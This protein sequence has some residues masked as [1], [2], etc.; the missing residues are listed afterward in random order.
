MPSSILQ[1]AAQ[2]GVHLFLKDGALGFKARPGALT[3]ELRAAISANKA[4]L[5]ELLSSRVERGTA[6]R[7]E[8][9][10]PGLRELPLSYAQ[11][12]L[13]LLDQIDGA[14][15][16]YNMPAA[17]RLKGPL[18]AVAVERALTRIIERHES[19]RTVFVVGEGGAPQQR[20]RAA[21]GFQVQREDLSMLPPSDREAALQA[22]LE[23]DLARP[24]QLDRDWMLRALL[25]CLGPQDHA[26][27]VS[28]HHIASDGWSLGVL[29][30]EFSALYGAFS[31]GMDDPLPAL[32]LQ[33]GDYALWQRQHLDGA[34][35][36]AQ[37]DYWAEQLAGAPATHGLALD[38]AR[39]PQ[40]SFEGA[41]LS[42]TLEARLVERLRGLCQAGGASLFMGLHAAFAALLARHS[43]ETDIVMGTALAN[44][45]QAEIAGLIGFFVNS[46]CLRSD[47]GGSPGLR[48][49]VERSRRML[50][51]AYAHQQA[52]FEQV[53][54]RLQPER[55]MAHAP[56]FQVILTLQNNAQGEFASR[57]LSIEPIEG[58]TTFA[59]YDLTLD[60]AELPDGGLHISWDYCTA[61]FRAATI[62]RLARHFERLLRAMLDQPDHS[63]RQV[64]MLDEAERHQLVHGLNAGVRHCPADALAHELVARQ[65]AVRP[66]AVALV[67]GTER[68]SFGRLDRLANQLAHALQ[69]HGVGRDARVAVCLPRGMAWAVSLLGVMKA[70]GAYVPLYP[71]LP[72]QRIAFML[73]DSACSVAIVHSDH[74]A[75]VERPGLQRIC[76]DGMA[77]LDAL[78]GAF[79]EE[80]P[81][82]Q[83]LPDDLAYCVYT[84]G[85]TGRPKG[86]AIPHRSLLGFMRGVDYLQFDASCVF[87]QAASMSWDALTLELWPALCHGGTVVVYE[88]DDVTPEGIAQTISSQGVNTLFLPAALF[89]LM[90]DEQLQAFA[91]LKQMLS[92]GDR[93]SAPHARRLKDAYPRLRIVNGYGPV[94]CT[95]VASCH[96]V[97]GSEGAELP[98]G[99]PIGD[100]RIYLL[101]AEGGLAPLGAPGEITIAGGSV[102]REYLNLPEL[103]ASRFVP[104]PWFPGERMYRTGDLARWRADGILEYLGRA[105]HQVKIRGY[106]VELGEIEAALASCEGVGDVAVIALGTGAQKHLV[107]YLT[108]QS[109]ADTLRAVLGQ[110]L[111]AYMV[112]AVFMKLEA[113]PLTSNGKLDRKALPV[114]DFAAAARKDYQAPR[115]ELEQALCLIWQEVLGVERVGVTDN[116]FELGGHSLRATQV[117]SRVSQRLNLSAPVRALFEAP[118]IE[119]FA[120]QLSQTRTP[121]VR[122]RR[123][124][125]VAPLSFAQQ[126]LWLID[127]IEQSS[128][129]YNIP[130][131]L[132]LQ[133][134]LDVPAL[135]RAFDTILAR[136]EVL[137]STLVLNEQ[138]EPE[139]RV[140]PARGLPL[141]MLDLSGLPAA[142]REA[143][144]AQAL[145]AQSLLP[146]DLGRDLM[147]RLH[148]MRLADE[149]HV[150]LLVMHH[151]AADGWSMEVLVQEFT[152][153]YGAFSR[154]EPDPL[155]PL[156]LQYGDYAQW[157]HEHLQ[158]ENLERLFQYWERQLHDLPLVHSLPLDFPRPAHQRFEGASVSS[159]L[160]APTLARLKALCQ[161]AD[162][163]LFMGL[164][165]AF[166][167]LLARWSNARDIV[168]GMPIANREQPEIA[169]LIGFFVNTLVLRSDFS[170]R[171]D[172]HA[173]LAQSRRTLLEAFAHQQAPFE[174]LVERLRPERSMAY[175]P[176]FQVMLTLQ[177]FAEEGGEGMPGLT[178]SEVGGTGSTS[179]HDL[180]LTARE[181]E[182]ELVLDWEYDVALFRPETIERLAESFGRLAEGLVSQPQRNVF[183][184]PLLSPEEQEGLLALAPAARDGDTALRGVHQ[185]FEARCRLQ[186]EH[187]AV[188][189][190]GRTLSYA[191]LDGRANR[192]ARH[193]QARHGVGP[194]VVVGVCLERSLDMVVALLAVLKAGG[195]YAP[196]DPSYPA[197]RIHHVLAHAQLKT[198]LT[199]RR[200]VADGLVPA[201]SALCLDEPALQALLDAGPSVPP[202]DEGLSSEHLAY[203]IYTSG[204]TGQ[205]K[206]VAMPHAPLLNLLA[207]HQS[208]ASGLAAAAR[209]LQFAALGFD[210]AFQEVFSTLATGGQLF[211]VDEELRRDPVRLLAFIEA[212][213]LQRLFLPVVALQSLCEAA[214]TEAADLSSLQDVVVAGEQLRITPA[215][216]RFAERA[217]LLGLH[218][219][220]GPTETHVVTALRMGLEQIRTQPLPPI[221]RP[222]AHVRILIL[223]AQ[224]QLVPRG[225]VGEL[226]VAGAALA[227]GYHRE[228]QLTQQRFISCQALVPEGAP[229]GLDQDTRLYKT[230][231]L[232][233]WLPDG[234]LEFL[235]RSDHQVKI[236]GFRIEL[237]EIE[238]AL[239][240]CDGVR[241]A[242]VVA[243]ELA[244]EQKLVAYFTG[245]AGVVDVAA[246]R[247]RLSRQLPEYM[248]PAAFV[249]LEALPQT[250]NG[251]L[252]RKALPAPELGTQ[253]RE[254]VAPRT[255][256]EA[257][258]CEIWQEV[259]GVAQVGVTD[260]FFELGGHSLRAT[261]LLA[262]ISQRLKLSAPV[263]A[264]FEA[265]TV[266]GLAAQLKPL[267]AQ[268]LSRRIDRTR[269]PLSFAQQRLWLIDRIEQSSVH[270]HMP[271]ALRLQGALDLAALRRAFDTIL[272]RHEV[273]RTVLVLDEHG[274]P[275]QQ[276]QPAVPLPLELI[277]LSALTG[278][279]QAQAVEQ[280]LATHSLQPFDLGRDL[281]LR[282]CLLRLG[283]Q[284]HILLVV[285]HHIASD[286]WSMNVLVDEFTAL[287]G[288]FSAHQP[289]PLPPLALQ[290]GDY[291]QWQRNTLQGGSLA[292]L[293]GYWERQLHDLPL[294][295]G[296]P[297][298][299]PRPAEQRFEG[300]SLT[301]RLP[302][303]L[304]QS[305]K[306]LCL[307]ADASFFMGLHA[308]FSVLL[309]RWSAERD[310][311][312]GTPIANRE[313]PEIAPLIG[314]FVNT[315]VLRSR[316][317]PDA[318]FL[319]LIEHSRQTILEAFA[320]QQAPFDHLVERLK[321]E[322]SMAYT[323]LFQVMLDLQDGEGEPGDAGSGN[324]LQGL[325]LGAV[326]GGGVT[327]KFDLTLTA[328]HAQGGLQLEW[329]YSTALF[330]PETLQRM[331]DS[332]VRLLQALT[333]EPQGRV[334]QHPMLEAAE[335]QRLTRQWN[336]TTQACPQGQGLH[337]LFEQQVKRTPQA[338]AL[339]HQGQSLSYADLNAGANRLASHLRERCHVGD[340]T[341]VGL[342][343][344][345]GVL[346]LMAVLGIWKAGGAY[347]PLDVDQPVQRL[348]AIADEAA[349]GLVLVPGDDPALAAAFEGRA[350]CVDETLLTGEL[351]RYSAHDL[352]QLPGRE[353]ALAYVIFTSGSTGKPKGVMVEHRSVVNLWEGLRRTA[354]ALQEPGATVALN[355]SL[356][357]D[358]SV[359]GL[360]QLLSGH[361]LVVVPKEVRP[362]AQALV[363]W[364]QAQRV[365]VVDCTPSQLEMWVQAGLLEQQAVRPRL[366]IGGEAIAP[367]LWQ[368]L[369]ASGWQAF[370]VYGPTECTVDASWAAIHAGPSLPHIGRPLGHVQAYVLNEVGQLV[371]QGCAGELCIAGV[372][373]ARGYLNRDELTQ[374]KFVPNPFHDEGDPGS[375]AR[376]YRTGDLARWR[377]D[378][379]LEYLGRLDHQ[380]KIRGFRIELGEI[381]AALAACEGV[382]E[383]VVLAREVGGDKKL[384][385]YF[386]GE[387]SKT[388]GATLR[389]KLARQLPDYMVPSAF[390]ALET[391]PLTPN[392]KLDR[393]ALPEPELG[394]QARE[395]VAPRNEVEAQLCEIWQE[396]LGVERVSVKDDF[397]ELGGHSLTALRMVA[398][399][400]RRLG[401]AVPVRLLFQRRTLEQL[402][403]A[404]AE[405]QPDRQGPLLC[406]T[407]GQPAQHAPVFLV[408]P[409]EGEVDYVRRLAAHLPAALPVYGLAAIGFLPGEVPLR[410]VPDMAR[411]YLEA[412]RHVQPR[413]PYRLAGWSAGGTIACEMAAQLQR[414]GETVEFLGLIDTASSYAD[415]AGLLPP[416]TGDADLDLAAMLCADLQRQ[417]LPEAL[418]ARL[419][420]LAA[421]GDVPGLLAL[422]RDSQL[423]PAELPLDALR[424]HAEVRVGILRALASY[425]RP[426]LQGT[427]HLF[428]AEEGRACPALGWEAQPDLALVLETLDGDHDSIVAEPRVGLLAARMAR[429]LMA[430][431][432]T[433]TQREM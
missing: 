89:S 192:L 121:P 248:V 101:D 330:R 257:Q 285:M 288:A 45:E 174:Q 342:C 156:A 80:A 175:S 57:D 428:M 182:G 114:P 127:R 71:R 42:Q 96:I 341:L 49:L 157:Q 160:P 190:E 304:V 25:V 34:A 55:S 252:D 305:L 151:V 407:P 399:L 132:R 162:A 409:G 246:L 394:G 365:E 289:D 227:R 27:L 284:E 433:P 46:V 116:F 152:T 402:A 299:Y 351:A 78:L 290:Y 333:S 417:P 110:R 37:L 384:V 362:D 397:F 11:Q 113:L 31:Q 265:P 193:L 68:L 64:D 131:A 408:H 70:G 59:K 380:V 388:D 102:A 301:T 53:V 194:D 51:Q 139:Q 247:E 424:R 134:P 302:T 367:A 339:V 124:R 427:I 207:W 324:A 243:R 300:A 82:T 10:P 47:L 109:D 179:K 50:L 105:D 76:I 309:A 226:Y 118:T 197:Q 264:L 165:A 203:V 357:F 187:P 73:E 410:R 212:V 185:L 35:L 349:L 377:E 30:N 250:P 313:Q 144:V 328:R 225:T 393:K 56:L 347:V 138:G 173:A 218:N 295:H 286:G 103:S 17:L 422:C 319:Q 13:W 161:Q 253:G 415:L 135:Q 239:S 63:F 1:Q 297:L 381:E 329:V 48:E 83:V 205:P 421:Q 32:E 258:L 291:A 267:Q 238:V 432:A 145:Q 277:D 237:G 20:I 95:V 255:E 383:A 371:P 325:A 306:A 166:G 75:L 373:L 189:F 62:E 178:I 200:L 368:R 314:F 233:R 411:A 274:E 170:E 183:L 172:F 23:R 403:Q 400:D 344:P 22:L 69:T 224:G 202:A 188:T 58:D 137:R 234:N 260:H 249:P 372:G 276:V 91:P 3:A 36:Q 195:A 332:F 311:V 398:Q 391:L 235:G 147:L 12:R 378:G 211:L 431:A 150:L 120:L 38:A 389:E 112:P 345:R 191:E 93:V 4:A 369:Q 79:S 272:A 229:L 214:Q 201:G 186:P 39:P 87:L 81:D 141:A 244:S 353:H 271:S 176:L 379:V 84:S 363:Q 184:G 204:S 320:H 85:S 167:V 405:G 21:E 99:R 414:S 206:G 352:P 72:P 412:L 282:A 326:E 390:M 327:A 14:G 404:L 108:G 7:I 245:E 220:Y 40:Q 119:G 386:T 336:A 209:T 308:A 216:V 392:G 2:Q 360:V 387:T 24:F 385:A 356:V 364:L 355:A 142:S 321:P 61:L 241:E 322:R 298:D 374:E 334:F 54:E 281:M 125:A 418:L 111:P 240:A 273:L 199:Q 425:E 350:L 416:E 26:L 94:E 52:P 43:G 401:R 256:L 259:L 97:D 230:G 117:L 283:A 292:Q 65:A 123:D 413:G 106:R 376:M 196:L 221:G 19:L 8:R 74:A 155:P 215:V 318:S 90:V 208:D 154:Q 294:V 129:H 315:L 303:A 251:K 359:Q 60:C 426:R 15:A 67:Q 337:Q 222:I 107:A 210:V 338:V 310:I 66:E 136:H 198:V 177:A 213:Q 331:A 317:S 242:V 361:R 395:Y 323:P 430:G 423:M 29:V 236:R 429:W 169:P 223:D 343:L 254:Y 231:D 232:A 146:F 270:Y 268:P 86:T 16:Q 340:E 296:Q 33:Y 126:R 278:P 181:F 133:G 279:D 375:S 366:V 266:Q 122:R 44:R 280:A 348:Q 104:D 287:Y 346:Q 149:D 153:L 28:M 88:G 92:G 130:N 171:Q 263:R 168:L 9:R 128:A 143:A 420:G 316:L 163:T 115:T 370:N 262:R 261:Q 293:L 219:H 269:A 217:R 6:A 140:Q 358:A 158:G 335:A 159:R 77:S 275:Q 228:A 307:Q 100:R 180:M 98:I 419:Q 148:L 382:R 164:H 41:R 18:D 312:M 354:Y 396:V 406:F 5:I